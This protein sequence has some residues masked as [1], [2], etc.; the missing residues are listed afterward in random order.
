MLGA[1]QRFGFGR[2]IEKRLRAVGPDQASQRGLEFGRQRSGRG[3]EDAAFPFDHHRARLGQARGD[4]GD[5][6]RGIVPRYVAH[7]LGARARLAEAASGAD[8]PDAP[9]AF[10]SELFVAAPDFP[11]PGAQRLALVRAQRLVEDQAALAPLLAGLAEPGAA[12]GSHPNHRCAPG[13]RRRAP[14]WRPAPVPPVRAS[15]R[16]WR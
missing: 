1:A 10:G 12:A 4:E 13:S 9:V 15:R 3:G 16:S 11:V 2:R 14:P 8:Q 5:A 6:R 7:P